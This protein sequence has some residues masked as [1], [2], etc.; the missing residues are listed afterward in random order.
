[1]E[2]PRMD[3]LQA[4]RIYARVAELGSFTRA[5]ADLDMSR[6]AVSESVAALEKHLGARLLARTTRQVAPTDDG[7][8]YL[9]RCRRILAEVD[10]AEAALRDARDRPQ[11]HLRVDLPPAFGRVLLLPALPKF[12]ERYPDLELD[13]RFNDRVV[14]LVAE[15]VDVAMRSGV[16]RSPDLVARRIA[17]SRRIIV[18]A[19]AY[20]ASAGTPQKPDDLHRHRLIGVSSG[21][22]GRTLQWVL[23]G[24][25][26]PK[27]KFAVV[28]NEVEALLEAAAGGAG[29]AQTVD[30]LAGG[31]IARGKL[32]TVLD[33]WGTD[34]PPVSMVSVAAVHRSAKV[35]VF[36]DFCAQLLAKWREGLAPR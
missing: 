13:V 9:Q 17:T 15:R 5:A 29:L 28:F 19:P 21:T 11:G 1:M 31:L 14:D 27:L 20:L 4:M 23:R 12:L 24:T 36:S 32:A 2:I 18:G 25:K 16:V 26:A 30:L 6:A 3:R 10:A 7:Q 33:A 35:R 34:G 8:D 22:T